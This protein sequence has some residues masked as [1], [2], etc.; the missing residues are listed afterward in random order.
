MFSNKKTLNT[1][2]KILKFQNLPS[3]VLENLITYE[4]IV[5]KIKNKY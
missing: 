4:S 2:L 1:Q 5:M 3:F